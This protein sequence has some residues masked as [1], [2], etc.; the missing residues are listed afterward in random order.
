VV[1]ARPDGEIRRGTGA[2]V[3]DDVYNGTGAGQTSAGSARQTK[4]VTY[5]VRAQND[6]GGADRLRLRGQGSTPRFK[7][8]YRNPAG[9]NITTAVTNGT[10]RTPVLAPDATHVVK[11]VVTV[12]GTAPPGAAVARTVTA[13]ST[14]QPTTSDTVRFVTRRA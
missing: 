13:V 2:W 1:P 11:V 14:N 4:S 7:V 10:Y 3:G 12:R 9:A 8:V 6:A 5:Y